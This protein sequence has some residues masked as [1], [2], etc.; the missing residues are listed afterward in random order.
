MKTCVVL[1]AFVIIDSSPYITE[2]FILHFKDRAKNVHLCT[3]IFIYDHLIAF[4]C[5]GQRP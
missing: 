1:G 4:G 5:F 3:N 2:Y